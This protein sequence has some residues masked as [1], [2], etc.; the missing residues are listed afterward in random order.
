LLVA[1]AAAVFSGFQYRAVSRQADISEQTRK[2]GES[3]QRP[4]L[5]VVSA[6]VK[7]TGSGSGAVPSSSPMVQLT[8]ASFG[9]APAFHIVNGS[10]PSFPNS[11]PDVS[12]FYRSFND[13]SEA[14]C[15][16]VDV[17]VKGAKQ[18]TISLQ[19]EQPVTVN[20]PLQ[21]GGTMFPG[22][23]LLSE[24]DLG[25][26]TSPPFGIFGCLGYTGPSQKP[27]HHTTYCFLSPVASDQLKVGQTLG[28][29]GVYQKAD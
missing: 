18:V 15:A 21:V 28:R 9:T 19:G 16:L 13:W 24:A 7:S 25:A 4:W 3:V 8:I 5:S 26:P 14:E 12:K 10:L 11:V 23:T 17:L 6:T 22:Q 2:D 1:A 27:I 29:C 20:M